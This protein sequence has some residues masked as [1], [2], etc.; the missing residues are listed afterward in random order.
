M[1][2]RAGDELNA[3][4]DFDFFDVWR[5]SLRGRRIDYTYP[6]SIPKRNI[7]LFPAARVLTDDRLS[8]KDP[9]SS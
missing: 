7:R 5:S 9:P 3:A 4:L 6:L 8:V 1:A 2:E